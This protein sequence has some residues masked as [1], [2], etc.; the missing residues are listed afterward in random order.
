M[1]SENIMVRCPSCGTKNRI[2]GNRLTERPICGKCKGYLPMS[3]P[4]NRPVEINDRTFSS[5]VLSLP[6]L[7]LVDCWA[8]WC[9]PCR[10]VAPVLNQ[11]AAQYAGRI[12]VTKVNVDENSAVAS[13]FAVQ[14]IP[15][16]LLFKGGKLVDRMVGA[17][18][19]A[20]I[21]RHLLPHLQ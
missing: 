3:T 2:P 6:G 14:S 18:P 13:Q 10:M 11:L 5:E 8:P 7:V 17:L 19:K 12:K 20:D 4:N 9:G 15:T 21:E 16:L 1:H